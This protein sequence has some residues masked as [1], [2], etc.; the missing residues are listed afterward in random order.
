MRKLENRG[1]T[2]INVYGYQ[3]REEKQCASSPE[4]AGRV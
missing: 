4:A 2:R 3:E 1:R